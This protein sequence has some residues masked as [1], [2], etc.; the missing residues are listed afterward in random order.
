MRKI[1]T[2]F[3]IKAIRTS[4][5]PKRT[6]SSPTT[7]DQRD[8]NMAPKNMASGTTINDVNPLNIPPSNVS[9]AII[10]PPAAPRR[11]HPSK[12]RK[13]NPQRQATI[14]PQPTRI[15]GVAATRVYPSP[16]K[17]KK[18]LPNNEV[19]P[20]IGLAPKGMKRIPPINKAKKIAQMDKKTR[21]PKV[22]A[23]FLT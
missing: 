4:F 6:L 21:F 8:P 15:K 18:A 10:V 20:S 11:M 12:P 16:L 23:V 2:K 22:Q 7:P 13:I 1:A 5:P 3:I 14:V 19:Y 17:V 9:K